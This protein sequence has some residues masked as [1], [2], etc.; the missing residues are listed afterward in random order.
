MFS[1][2]FNPLENKSNGLKSKCLNNSESAPLLFI[3]GKSSPPPIE[4]II[5]IRV[6]I[7]VDYS[8]FSKNNCR[9]GLLDYKGLT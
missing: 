5:D 2:V 9:V 6:F 7:D 1:I 8:F 3:F 4:T